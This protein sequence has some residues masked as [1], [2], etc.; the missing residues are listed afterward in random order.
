[1]L[2]DICG[3]VL[4]YRFLSNPFLFLKSKYGVD[5]PAIVDIWKCSKNISRDYNIDCSALKLNIIL[6]VFDEMKLIELSRNNSST[7]QITLLQTDKKVNLEESEFLLK[8]KNIDKE[9]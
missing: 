8:F 9:N 4:L 7:S 6:T 2:P 1:M 3:I 5:N